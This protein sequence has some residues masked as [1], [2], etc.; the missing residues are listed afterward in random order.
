MA[1]FASSDLHGNGCDNLT[2]SKAEGLTF[3]QA[4]QTSPNVRLIFKKKT[5]ITH[6][7]IAFKHPVKKLQIAFLRDGGF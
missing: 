7:K 4:D 5:P 1:C 6:R 2:S 3:H